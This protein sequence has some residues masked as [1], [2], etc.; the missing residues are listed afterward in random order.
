M[1]IPIVTATF[2]TSPDSGAQRLEVQFNSSASAYDRIVE[3]EGSIADDRIIEVE[4]STVSD[5]II[6]VVYG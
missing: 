4:G 3:V 1:S 6:E 5:R 2:T